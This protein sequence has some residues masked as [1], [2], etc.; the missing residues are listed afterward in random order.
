M[1]KVVGNFF[2][3]S[4]NEIK[5]E[6]AIA[7]RAIKKR[8]KKV[9]PKMKQ[10]RLRVINIQGAKKKYRNIG[11]IHNIYFFWGAPILFSSTVY[12]IFRN[13]LQKSLLANLKPIP[14]RAV[15]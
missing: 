7:G 4:F 13:Q 9:I 15:C 3:S 5:K 10:R 6:I 11:K 1:E 2:K 14:N 8:S 12:F